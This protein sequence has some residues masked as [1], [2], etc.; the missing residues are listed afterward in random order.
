MQHGYLFQTGWEAERNQSYTWNYKTKTYQFPTRFIWGG[1]AADA[2]I[3]GVGTGLLCITTIATL[4]QLRIWWRRHRHACER[5]GYD[6]STLTTGTPCPE[7]GAPPRVSCSSTSSAA[8]KHSGTRRR[9]P[10][11]AHP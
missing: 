3:L 4:R 5:C 1:L 8:A 10:S 11:P 9:A 2:A 6:T 7:C